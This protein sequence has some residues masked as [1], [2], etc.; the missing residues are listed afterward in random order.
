VKR[1]AAGI[2]GALLLALWPAVAADQASPPASKL[3]QP[4]AARQPTNWTADFGAS[5][6]LHAALQAYETNPS[7]ATAL[8]VLKHFSEMAR[9][10]GMRTAMLARHHDFF[11]S[12]DIAKYDMVLHTIEALGGDVGASRRAG[13]SAEWFRKIEE[14]VRNGRRDPAPRM[15]PNKQFRSDDDI[16]N[17]LR[18]DLI[19]SDPVNA[20]SMTT[21]DRKS[22]V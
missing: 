11:L 1:A 22:V 8:G 12:I 16:T 7:M 21:A 20:A 18:A 10:D 3:F 4:P 6:P 13:S 2:L 9:N 15:D 14:W 5:A 17:L 19:I